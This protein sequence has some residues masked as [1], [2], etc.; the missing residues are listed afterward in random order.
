LTIQNQATAGYYGIHID[1]GT[2]MVIDGLTAS[3]NSTGGTIKID[4]S[5]L[6]LYIRDFTSSD[7]TKFTFPATTTYPGARVY[8]FSEDGTYNNHNITFANGVVS[9]V[10]A[11][12]YADTYA[13]KFTPNASADSFYP[14]EI[15][16]LVYPVINENVDIKLFVNLSNSAMT[17]RLLCRGGQVGGVA[18]DV[19]IDAAA[20]TGWQEVT[21]PLTPNEVGGCEIVFQVWGGNG[22]TDNV[23]ID[24]MT[25]PLVST[26]SLEHSYHGPL[27][28]ID[29]IKTRSLE[30]ADW[31]GLMPFVALRYIPV[32]YVIAASTALSVGASIPSVLCKRVRSILLNV[33]VNI[34][35]SRL[36]KI[37]R[38]INTGISLRAI[39][40]K[41]YFTDIASALNLH[42]N[43]TKG[44]AYEAICSTALTVGI[45]ASRLLNAI[46]NISLQIHPAVNS[47]RGF[48]RNILIALNIRVVTKP[49][50]II[51][52]NDDDETTDDIA[53]ILTISYSGG[54]T[55]MRLKNDDTAWGEWI[56]PATSKN[57]A[58]KAGADG[59]KTVY[60]QVRDTAGES[61]IANDSIELVTPSYPLTV[62]GEI[63]DL[64]R[65]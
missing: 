44:R 28:Y 21:L 23:M 31:L 63:T 36:A 46:R 17:G 10:T 55:D 19:F 24:A 4:N 13:W 41:K 18:S 12:V 1:G 6:R 5:N 33:G 51:I 50:C 62:I 34:G 65:A 60:L 64:V 38:K 9:C 43:F 3:G 22:T 40:Y 16:V 47:L 7:A 29:D 25:P 32:P 37:I 53:S 48:V 61:D 59:T 2:K 45:T 39:Q 15:P 30:V 8:S 58:L 26:Y 52:I 42:I 20:S 35:T 57:W 11:G 27:N 49:T 56:T 14:V 54:V